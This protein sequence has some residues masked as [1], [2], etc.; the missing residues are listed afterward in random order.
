MCWTVSAAVA[1]TWTTTGR[2]LIPS[3]AWG[4]ARRTIAV[5][6]AIWQRK[7]L[8]FF[9]FFSFAVTEA[10]RRRR[11]VLRRSSFTSAAQTEP[12]RPVDAAAFFRVFGSEKVTR[13]LSHTPAS[14][15]RA[16]HRAVATAVR[17]TDNARPV[18]V[19]C[20]FFRPN[21]FRRPVKICVFAVP[22][23]IASVRNLAALG[24]RFFLASRTMDA[25]NSPPPSP[26]VR[27]GQWQL[28]LIL[29]VRDEKNCTYADLL[30]GFGG[31]KQA[32]HNYNKKIW[33]YEIHFEILRGQEGYTRIPIENHFDCGKEQNTAGNAFLIFY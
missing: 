26:F 23:N 5:D 19:A 15:E 7:C 29:R 9:F 13:T 2:N 12:H 20:G 8:F 25:E 33:C 24:R 4:T 11:H 21:A 6:S 1:P 18:G 10:A 31:D 3:I 22:D 27:T 14:I 16:L 17:R 28:Y 30:T 32:T